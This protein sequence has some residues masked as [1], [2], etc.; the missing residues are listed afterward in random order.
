MNLGHL[1]FF[2]F[3]FP[4]SL[5]LTCYHSRLHTV[6]AR[7]RPLERSASK[8]VQGWVLTMNRKVEWAPLL[9]NSSLQRKITWSFVLRQMKHFTLVQVKLLSERATLQLVT[10]IFPEIFWREGSLENRSDWK[11]LWYNKG[12][13]Y[14]HSH[15]Q[16]PA[17]ARE[18]GHQ[19]SWSRHT[20]WF[21]SLSQFLTKRSSP[22][23]TWLS[24]FCL[25]EVIQG[26]V[27]TGLCTMASDSA[28]V[29]TSR[30][31]KLFELIVILLMF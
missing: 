18:T 21:S 19:V 22:G 28:E 25:L 24:V 7:Q 15:L 23:L 11:V 16:T 12:F 6:Q 29:S 10:I 26:V 4:Y 5:S 31:Y 2:N 9:P 27:T 17:A 20:E 8:A 14:P 3:K 30:Y 13:C 1:F